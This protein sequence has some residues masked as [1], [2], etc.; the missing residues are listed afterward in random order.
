MRLNA[1]SQEDVDDGGRTYERGHPSDCNVSLVLATGT[2][3]RKERQLDWTTV[4]VSAWEAIFMLVVLKIPMV[5][6]AVVVWW[7]VRAEPEVSGGGDEV[8]VLAPLTPCAWNDWKSR[9]PPRP[10]RGPARRRRL[11]PARV[12]AR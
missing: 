2:G 7:A 11:A 8:A 1:V 10:S 12:H 6:L 4:S 5:Y 3:S 9:R